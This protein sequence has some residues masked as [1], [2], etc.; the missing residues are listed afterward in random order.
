M[1]F[2]AVYR[3]YSQ[4]YFL[5]GLLFALLSKNRLLTGVIKSAPVPIGL[6]SRTSGPWIFGKGGASVCPVSAFRKGQ[7]YTVAYPTLCWIVSHCI[8]CIYVF[9]WWF[10]ANIDGLPCCRSRVRIAPK[11]LSPICCAT[12]SRDRMIF[13]RSYRISSPRM[14]ISSLIERGK[15]WPS[16]FTISPTRR[17]HE[18]STPSLRNSTIRRRFI[19]EPTWCYA[20]SWYRLRLPQVRTYPRHISDIS[21]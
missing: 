21:T 5:L 12:T 1:P 11:R 19:R 18:P 17:R 8:T 7:Y 20:T 6:T 13:E 4:L 14:P 3:Y 9:F 2:L 10:S 16:A 15:P